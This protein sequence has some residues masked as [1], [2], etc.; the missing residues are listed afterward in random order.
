MTGPPFESDGAGTSLRLEATVVGRVQGVGFRYHVLRTALDLDLDGWVAN[1]LDGSVRA[2]AEGPRPAL[3]RLLEA[4]Q[5]GPAGALVE[6]VIVAWGPATGTLGPF[7]I[8]SHGHRG[9]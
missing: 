8:R 3:E 9:D 6:R 2:R 5:A 7:G 1:E 4:M